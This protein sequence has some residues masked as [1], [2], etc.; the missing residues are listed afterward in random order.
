M[1]YMF[2]EKKENGKIAENRNGFTLIELLVVIAIIAILAA[3]LLP[4]LAKAKAKAKQTNC[5]SNMRQLGIAMFMYTG[6]NGDTLPVPQFNGTNAAWQSYSLTKNGGTGGAS[7]DFV[8]NPPVNHGVFYT[9]KLIANGKIFYCP[10]MGDGAQEQL[11]YAYQSY[12]D[13]SGVW[14]AYN[15]NPLWNGNMRSSY[16]YYPCT[17]AY[18]NGATLP[19]FGAQS[20]HVVA[21]KST[22][23]SA[24]Q[25][26]MTDLI[27]DYASIPHRSGP[28][29]N[30]LNVLWG[31]GHVKASTTPAAFNDPTLWGSN[32]T[33]VNGAGSP[34]DAGDTPNNFNKIVSYLLP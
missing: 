17:A 25:V 28:Q 2:D 18:I 13:G 20:G 7:V 14:P 12:V 21:V 15:N 8:A 10:A 30:S 33:G 11:K 1:E 9:T 29:P 24:V 32:P 31:D 6:D 23:L 34:P 22:Q 4:V 19:I 26:L 27:Y 5:L 16:M 3:M